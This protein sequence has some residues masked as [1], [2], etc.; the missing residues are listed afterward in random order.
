MKLWELEYS[1][2][3]HSNRVFRFAAF[4]FEHAIEKAKEF[5]TRNYTEHG[6]HGGYGHTIVRLD[7]V[8]DFK[9]DQKLI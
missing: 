2:A 7:Y 6:V 5:L 8:T 9:T 4:D 3:A 1:C